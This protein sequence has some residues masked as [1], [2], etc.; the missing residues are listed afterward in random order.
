MIP[1]LFYVTQTYVKLSELQ[2]NLITYSF[3]IQIAESRELFDICHQLCKLFKLL[4]K[5]FM[6][7]VKQFL[8]PLSIQ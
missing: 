4:Q 8:N 6:S 7:I 3:L 2:P 1:Q 5:L